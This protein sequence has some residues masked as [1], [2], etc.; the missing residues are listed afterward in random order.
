MAVLLGTTVDR[1][2]GQP[3]FDYVFPED[4]PGAQ[5]LF[6]LK[7]RGDMSPFEFRL[8]RSDGTPVWVSVQGTPMHDE[9]GAFRGVIG[10]FRTIPKQSSDRSVNLRE[11]SADM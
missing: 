2:L 9:S 10:T 1:L 3:S 11:A 4:V 6:E 7:S 5:R 8:R